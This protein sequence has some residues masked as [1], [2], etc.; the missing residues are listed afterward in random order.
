MK[1]KVLIQNY[2]PFLQSVVIVVALWILAWVS[3]DRTL[4]SFDLFNPKRVLQLIFALAL[5]QTLGSVL[6]FW[7]GVKAGS[8]ASG[9]L[10][11]L[12]SSTATTAALAKKSQTSK[13]ITSHVLVFL[14]TNLAML[15]EA[16]LI[17]MVGSDHIHLPVIAVILCPMFAIAILLIYFSRKENQHQEALPPSTL[18]PWGLIKLTGFIFFI[19]MTSKFLQITFG[20]SGIYLITF[21]VSLFEIHGSMIANSQIHN[22]GVLQVT[23]L[24]LLVAISLFAAFL[25]KL[26]LVFLLA[27]KSFKFLVLKLT[28]IFWGALLAGVIIFAWLSY[29]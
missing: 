3:P 28:L 10:G 7:L 16:I 17:I 14:S 20:E 18:D 5:V 12:V 26:G 2:K 4:F 9:F 24:G 13:N 23:Q 8:V 29:V 1:N 22:Q 6:I 11:G 27:E 21:L 25:S 15:A 19:L